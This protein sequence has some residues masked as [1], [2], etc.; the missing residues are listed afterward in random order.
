V[1]AAA[2]T[3]WGPPANAQAPPQP[4]ETPAKPATEPPPPQA[5]PASPRPAPGPAIEPRPL[6]TFLLR[7]SKGNLVPVLGMSFDD[8]EQLLKLKQG[9]AAPPPPGFTLDALSIVGT[10]AKGVADL[11]ITLTIR[12]RDEGWV[13]VPLAMKSAVLR[14][15]PTHEGP[16]EHDFSF[17]EEKGGYQVWLRNDPVG[18]PVGGLRGSGTKPHVLTLRAACN[19]AV[20]GEE[21]SLALPL[22]RATES[23]LRL[24]IA[25]QRW[26]A[27]L[28]SGEGLVSLAP[29]GGGDTEISV[30]GPA[31]DLAL[32]WRAS[33]EAAVAGPMLLDS[34]GEIVVK[35]ESENRI[36]SDARLRVRSLGAS[37]ASFQVRLPAGMELVPTS[38]VGYTVSVVSAPPE[39]SGDKS[40]GQVQVVEIRLDKPTTTT[41]EVRLLA[42][43]PAAGGPPA[44]L[45]PARFDVVNAVRQRGTIDFA[46]EGQWQLNWNDDPTVQRLDIAA[47]AAAAKLAAR[48]EYSRQPCGLVLRVAPRPSR[49]SVEPLHIVDVEP[50]QIRITTSLKYRLRG[51]R[52]AGLEFHLGDLRFDR[53]SPEDLLEAPE[54]VGADG[55]LR[56]PFRQGVA[57]PP[58]LDLKLET[59][60]ALEEGA[61]Q[62]FVTLP[63]PLADSVA[64]AT[65]AVWP[66]DNVELTTQAGLLTGLSPDASPA[67]SPLAPH[68]QR[69]LVY[70]D[71]GGTEPA[72][73]GGLIKV[74]SRAVL[75]SAAASVR[76]EQQLL[77]IEQRLIY[78]IAHEPKR[79]FVLLAPRGLEAAGSVSVWSG[80]DQLGVQALADPPA[81]S[82]SLTRLQF[83]TASDQIGNFP[84]TVR[85]SLPL[86]KWDG[87]K[88]LPVTIPLVLPEDEPNYQFGGQEIGFDVESGLQVQP[89]S[90]G[91][92]EFSRP[93]VSAANAAVFTWPK[94][95]QTSRWILQPL[96]DAP[97]TLIA[98]EKAWIQTWL[99]PDL[100][101]ERVA[102]R[103]TSSAEALRVRLPAGV[104]MSSVQ[105]A[106]NS[107]S[108]AVTPRAPS[109]LRIDLPPAQ[110]GRPCVL[111]LW[112]SLPPP[113]R[114]GGILSDELR[115][116][117]LEEA[118]PPR[119]SYWQLV[120]T[121]SDQLLM[122]SD[123]MVSE[124]A[125]APGRWLAGPQPLLGQGELE[126]WM[127]ASRQDPLP[128]GVNA[129]LFGTLAQSPRLPVV[130]ASR[131]LTLMVASGL[132]LALGLLLIYVPVLRSAP[133]LL[134][135]AIVLAGLSLAF[136]DAALLL[137][138]AALLGLAVT[139]AVILWRWLAWGPP[140]RTQGTQ[141]TMTAPATP[142][143][144]TTQSR[145]D[146][147]QHPL[148]TATAPA[149]LAGEPRP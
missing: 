117:V 128:A 30:L 136:P 34:A 38:P 126:N 83:S 52:A 62:F 104:V 76:M 29:K 40:A 16:G 54:P 139:A 145:P 125:W 93:T 7:D 58:E 73:F 45:A 49:V 123:A 79:S 67:P 103:L 20:K 3:A 88:P 124:M 69:P 31:G 133:V 77:Q 148:T 149:A 92:D 130:V 146:R 114:R 78:R 41:A 147:S 35:V 14:E 50:R 51:S 2:A 42:T 47:D 137:G 119:R 39:A 5:V 107:Q 105:A 46:V 132:T 94:A 6:D 8:F 43:T 11:Q 111:E 23:S 113:A 97:G 15:P 120:L 55:V 80:A 9:L 59:H 17:D 135:A 71:L 19:L 138:R 102:F 21:T 115:P 99:T 122:S 75:V 90:A 13:G 48:F 91:L 1:I 82:A 116:A 10:A 57:L 127:S 87:Q 98:C 106:I 131:R 26:D 84:V 63:R 32:G 18:D 112:Y 101:Q 27:S 61:E 142:V 141:S 37:L 72:Q 129:H 110:R 33:R 24:T 44:N 85:Y 64:P 12:V 100:R 118:S 108:V 89:E 68:Q 4:A 60:H 65:V 140:V 22:P 70:R 95:A 28:S 56:V 74:R 143:S 53:L 66:A 134:A 86:P 109:L 96:R 81:R 36:S 144:S 121:A 25:G